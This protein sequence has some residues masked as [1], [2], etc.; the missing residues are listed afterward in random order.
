MRWKGASWMVQ[1]VK[2]LSAMQEMQVR[3]LNPWR[4]KWQ[5]TPVFLP[6]K[7]HGQRSLMGY[8]PKGCKE[9]DTTQPLRAHTWD[10]K[11]SPLGQQLRCPWSEPQWSLYGEPPL[12]WAKQAF[13]DCDQLLSFSFSPTCVSLLGLSRLTK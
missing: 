7:S 9:S 3:S 5:A 12:P 1:R 8:S 11:A 6:G 10:R 4:R 13:G 2:N